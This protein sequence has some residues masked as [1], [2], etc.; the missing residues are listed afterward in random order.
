MNTIVVDDEIRLI[1][2]FPNEKVTLAWYQD[3]DVCK[4]VDDVDE[5]YTL[6]KLNKMYQY[7]NSHGEL[8]YI[9]YKGNEFESKFGKVIDLSSSGTLLSGSKVFVRAAARINYDTP[10][11][12]GTRR[13][14]F[15]EV[16]EVYVP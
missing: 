4:Q 2:Y 13:Y 11:G 8:Y 3:L 9:E 7:L 5:P 15:S 1:P 16:K 12:S 14:N 10:V 6:E